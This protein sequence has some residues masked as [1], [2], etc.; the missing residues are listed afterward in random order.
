MTNAPPKIEARGLFKIFGANPRLAMDMLSAGSSKEDVLKT[1][2]VVAIN[3]VNFSVATGEIFAVMGLSGSGKSTLVRCINRLVTPSAGELRIDGENINTLSPD[4]LRHIRLEKIAMVFQHFALFPHMNVV[5][6]VEYGLRL[7]KVDKTARRQRALEVMSMVGL[8]GWANA[9][10]DNLSGGMRQR[11]G[12]ARA[13]A[14]DPQILLMDEPFGALDPLI[15]REMHRELQQIQAALRMT[16]IL[17]THDLHEAL[18]LGDNIAIMRDG[19]IIQKGNREDIITKPAN[20]YVSSFAQDVDRSRVI[21]VGSIMTRAESFDGTVLSATEAETIMRQKG[22]TSIYVVDAEGK[23]LRLITHREV[24]AAGSAARFDFGN[25]AAQRFPVVSQNASLSEIFAFC[26]DG[27]P[28]A[29]ID[30]FGRLCGKVNPTDVLV[31]LSG[32]SDNSLNEESP[33]RSQDGLF[34]KVVNN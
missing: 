18:S 15:R 22:C 8:E 34:R 13:L 27:L 23:P 10:P 29:V 2:N 32:R 11:V 14:L 4:R 17:I 16:V 19:E 6:N 21:R 1:G 20:E 33:Y 31:S 24:L 26:G 5:E 25:Q 30:S 28:V 7:R 3:N 12:L 9:A